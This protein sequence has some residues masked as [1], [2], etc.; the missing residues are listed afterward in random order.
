MIKVENYE[1]LVRFTI[2]KNGRRADLNLIDTSLITNMSHL[3]EESQFNGKISEWNTSNVTDM[4]CMFNCSKFNQ[5]IG[6]WNTGK[7]K[8]MSWMLA[9]SKFNKYIGNWNISNLNNETSSIFY[10]SAFN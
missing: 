10:D 9:S 1:E 7:V 4:Q 5:P 3:F 2:T 8:D 6:R